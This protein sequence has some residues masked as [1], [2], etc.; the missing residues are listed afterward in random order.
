MR[1]PG[2]TRQEVYSSNHQF[3]SNS[4][5]MLGL[6]SEWTW[7]KIRSKYFIPSQVRGTPSKNG[8]FS[9]IYAYLISCLWFSI[10]TTI[11][12]TWKWN[13]RDHVLL[14]SVSKYRYS[15]QLDNL[16]YLRG[17]ILI[18][19][20]FVVFWIAFFDIL[21]S[22]LACCLHRRLRFLAI[23]WTST[24]HVRIMRIMEGN[25]GQNCY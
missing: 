1:K 16:I 24:I 9:L 4:A 23:S 13:P 12:D 25:T 6:V 17:S 8:R 15:F 18:R 2:R 11:K 19:M 3:R 20:H 7:Q 5:Q 14:L 10:S 22:M 21:F